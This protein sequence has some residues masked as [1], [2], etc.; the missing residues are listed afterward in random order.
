MTTV[1]MPPAAASLA[2]AIEPA[3]VPR[4][5]TALG[6]CPRYDFPEVRRALSRMLDECGGVRR[7]V[8]RKH[9]TIKTNLVNS[10][11]ADLG[12]VPLW[13]TVTVHPVVARALGSL[14][15]RYGAR[16]VTFC[17]QLPFRALDAEAFAGYGFELGRFNEQ[18]DGRA[19]MINTRNR[20]AHRDYAVVKVPGGGEV[21]S[22][23]EVN[24]IGRASCRE[25][26]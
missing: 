17:D 12:G 8:R 2:A 24:Q 20:G 1:G 11:E 21:A 13:L 15:V 18:M 3:R 22:A 23:W 10:S 7:L 25:R 6:L 26:V 19:R 9:V 5:P 16:S 14:L 4:A